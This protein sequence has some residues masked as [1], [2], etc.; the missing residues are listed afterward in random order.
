MSSNIDDSA[1]SSSSDSE[2]ESRANAEDFEDYKLDGYHPVSLGEAFNNFKY[3]VIQKLGWGH[4]STVWLVNEKKTNSYYALKI[5]KSKKSYY[6]SAM[7]ELQICGHI[8]SQY[9]NPE[10][11]QSLAIY[12]EKFS[13]SL[14]LSQNDTFVIKLCDNFVHY[15]MHG[16]HPCA[17]FEVMG[18]N[19]LD[20]IQHFELHDKF[21]D[22]SLVKLISIQILLGLDYI[23]R[24]CGVIH[25]DL[26]PENV[27]F[28]LDSLEL[29][30]FVK[31]LQNYKKKP[32]SMKFLKFLK[33]KLGKN[34]K[35]KAKKA[36]KAAKLAENKQE[37]ILNVEMKETTPKNITTTES[38]PPLNEKE[39][40]QKPLEETKQ[41]EKTSQEEIK[42]N[43]FENENLEKVEKILD[44]LDINETEPLKKIEPA[45]PY[46][47]ILETNANTSDYD[48]KTLRWK[49]H[50]L[51]P[52][53][54][55]IRIKLVDFG[56]A[57]W[58]TKHFTDRIQTREYRAPEA[59]LGIEY[60]SSADIW[61]FACIVFELLTNT[62]LFKPRKTEEYGKN[63][64]H[65]AL[66]IETLGKFPKNLALSGKKSRKY[67]NK[68]G[69]LIRIKGIK[70]YKIKDILI[71]DF[72]FDVKE[73]EEIE[74]FL[75]PMLEYDP[76]KRIDAQTALESKWLW[77]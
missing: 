1:S 7:D 52:L 61:S 50:I 39:I 15:G 20:L 46:S 76:R 22:I 23:H 57:C 55:K 29:E 60:S 71:H 38:N 12:R 54:N 11:Q 64:D 44:S 67:F 18:P 3:K 4:F 5:Q 40:P 31:D 9:Q 30:D 42:T 45:L 32:I 17:V 13:K 24:I 19:L 26:K 41:I 66:M 14:T 33:T 25:T 36:K 59:I 69:Q 21:C 65:L 28:A 72:H 43:V 70:E 49:D 56:N 34:N 35:K 6:E 16:K 73:A 75:L 68:N 37:N 48:P 27:M 63:D 51:I 62:F 8:S 2:F 10:W 58:T 47:P 53:D 77:S 74:E